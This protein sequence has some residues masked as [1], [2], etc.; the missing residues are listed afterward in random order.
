MFAVVSRI[1]SVRFFVIPAKAGILI[2]Y[3][4]PAFAGMTVNG[5]IVIYLARTLLYGSSE[6]TFP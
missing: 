1:L 4:I 5:E 3:K 2:W 6:R